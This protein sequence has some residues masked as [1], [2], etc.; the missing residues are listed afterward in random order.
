MLK[1]I[2]LGLDDTPASIRAQE[3]A[4][5]LAQARSARVT[6]LTVVDAARIAPAEPVPLGGG[7]YKQH[8]DAVL[9][10]RTREQLVALA[11][12]FAG[13]CHAAQLDCEATVT[14]GDAIDALV[15]ASDV[16]DLI[17]IGRDAAFHAE[18]SGK[19]SQ[20]VERLLRQNPRPLVVVPEGTG[21]A[22]RVLVAYDGS[23]PAMRALQ[24][25]CLLG[26]A[27]GSEVL[28]ANINTRRSDGEALCARAV[29]Y[30][31]LHGVAA[32]ARSV[33]TQSEPVTVL[34]EIAAELDVGLIVMGAFGQRGW[35]EY[36][37]GSTTDK[38]LAA[39]GS[40][41]FIYH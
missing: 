11:S 3:I 35:R 14:E 23:V 36:L 16:H 22:R 18:P 5:A 1:S 25:L 7:S 10:G 34:V 24:M 27:N 4:L 26:I 2:L 13:K 39:S 37:L 9:V 15:A 8:K 30:L 6:G 21:D 33:E 28:V 19:V 31:A 32:R 20:I 38:L 17:V 40:P 41:L 29:R 12:R